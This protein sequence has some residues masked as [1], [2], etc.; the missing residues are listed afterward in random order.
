MRLTGLD[1]AFLCLDRDVS[2]MHLGALAIFR[3]V[4]P[5]DPTRL[6][7]LLADRAQSLPQLRQRVQPAEFPLAAAQW[8]DDPG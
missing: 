3:P 5:G 7:A 6:A 2:P 8:V 4:H 1:T